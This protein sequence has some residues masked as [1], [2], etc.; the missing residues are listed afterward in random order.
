[1]EEI[2]DAIRFGKGTKAL[3]RGGV[4]GRYGVGM[5][6]ALC[7]LAPRAEIETLH[8][9]ALSTLRV[10]WE[11][12]LRNFHFPFVADRKPRRAKELAFF[13]EHRVTSGTRVRVYGQAPGVQLDKLRRLLTERYTP[14]IWANR[15]IFLRREGQAWLSI[16]DM[17]PGPLS[18]TIEYD[19]E[20]D[21]MPYHV[22]GGL[23]LQRNV[24]Y[25]RAFI[26][27][28]YRFVEE[29]TD[30]VKGLSTA[31][32]QIFLGEEWKDCLGTHKIERSEESES[33][34]KEEKEEDEMEGDK[35]EETSAPAKPSAAASITFRSRV[36]VSTR[37]RVSS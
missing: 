30:L 28:S 36:R 23:M 13:D 5:T 22:Y 9:G 2:N 18:D 37:R 21:D 31:H 12:C 32:L 17:N 15:E 35:E 14:G 20:I 6:D 8:D 11:E 10:D 24:V 3:R 26:G 25:N 34:D 16:E 7:K 4:L 29:T 27:Y 19:G 1:M 33:D